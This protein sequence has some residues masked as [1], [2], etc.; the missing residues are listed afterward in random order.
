VNNKGDPLQ[1]LAKTYLRDRIPC[2]FTRDSTKKRFDFV[3]KLIADFNVSGVIWYELLCCETYD[4][5]AYYFDKR[6][7]ER[8]IPMLTIESDFDVADGG[9]LRNRLDAFIEMVKGGP[10]DA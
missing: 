3:M 8:K 6:M 10:V 1:S 2:A 5:E 4:Q 7:Q 9:P